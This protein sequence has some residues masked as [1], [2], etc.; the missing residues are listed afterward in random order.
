MAPF[1]QFLAGRHA[2]IV[3]R[4]LNLAGDEMSR[5]LDMLGSGPFLL[6]AW[7]PATLMRLRRNPQWFA[8]GDHSADDGAARPFLDGYDAYFSP[9]Q[10]VFDQVVFE[11]KRVDTTDFTD[12]AALDQEQKTNL[13]DIVVEQTDAGGILASRLLVDRAPFKDDRVRRALQLAVDR[14]ALASGVYPT[15]DGALSARL[16]GPVAPVSPWAMAPADLEK[17]PGYRAGADR[18]QDVRDAKQL[19]AAAGG[20]A[21]GD[22][23]VSVAGIPHIIPGRAADLLQRQLQDALGV[24]VVAGTDP[25]GYAFI[26][27][28]LTRNLDGASDGVVPFTFGFEDGGVDLDDWVYGEFRSGQPR[29]TYRL[30]DATLDAML[31]KQRGEFDAGARRQQGLAIQDYLLANVNAR[32]DYLAPVSRRVTW[33]YVRNSYVPLWYGAA[34]KLADT[35]LD[36]SHPAWA[37]RQA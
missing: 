20:A 9:Q 37:E 5:D 32:L 14:R 3:P 30:Q 8:A 28:G 7:Q 26:A 23:H 12:V 19:W 35:W 27:F 36:T 16:S 21:L 13:A 1:L 15:L 29:N 6:D 2:F 4:D 11:H 31:D 18:E 17:R 24:R 33:G 34:D 25:S 22:L 10:D